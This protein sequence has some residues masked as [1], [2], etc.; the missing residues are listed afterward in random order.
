MFE[1]VTIFFGIWIW[2][3]FCTVSCV[4]GVLLIDLHRHNTSF[5]NNCLGE[6]INACGRHFE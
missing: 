6:K 4:P 2:L 3:F 1:I 5:R